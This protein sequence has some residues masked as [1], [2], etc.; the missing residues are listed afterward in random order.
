M[1]MYAQVGFDDYIISW[2]YE[3]SEN[4]NQIKTEKNLI[5]I[6]ECVKVVDG[7]AVLDKGKQQELINAPEVL[8]EME[9]LQQENIILNEKLTTMD[10]A[11]LELSDYV[12]SLEG[13]LNEG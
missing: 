3:E 2:S 5:G 11:F 1:K 4:H 12:F 6:L 13:K 7:I 9:Q 10:K 8:T